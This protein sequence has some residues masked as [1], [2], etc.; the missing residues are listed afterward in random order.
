MKLKKKN[1]H[2]FN[3][4][5]K[6]DI[7]PKTS[8]ITPAITKAVLQDVILIIHANRG[9]NTIIPRSEKTICKKQL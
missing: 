2:T 6:L 9:E 7:V 3:K 5:I 1:T 4:N 8:I